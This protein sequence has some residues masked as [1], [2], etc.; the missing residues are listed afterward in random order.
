MDQISINNYYFFLLLYLN[1][2]YRNLICSLALKSLPFSFL[3]YHSVAKSLTY[4]YFSGYKKSILFWYKFFVSESD[5][6]FASSF[7][8]TSGQ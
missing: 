4:L 7:P 6:L 3:T 2:V 8:M 1:K 5:T